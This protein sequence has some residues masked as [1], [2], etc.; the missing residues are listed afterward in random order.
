[1][2]E[3]SGF[4]GALLYITRILETGFA[5]LLVI[6]PLSYLILSTFSVQTLFRTLFFILSGVLFVLGCWRFSHT[7]Q[8]VSK[9]FGFILHEGF[10]GIFEL[11][12]ALLA[13]SGWDAWY[14]TLMSA[15]CVIGGLTGILL[16][17]LKC[18]LP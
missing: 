9:Y 8:L 5:A 14:Q 1:M 13:Y 2:A 11:V 18:L 15:T 3:I 10:R 17:I 4:A 16:M 12:I 7:L 6:A